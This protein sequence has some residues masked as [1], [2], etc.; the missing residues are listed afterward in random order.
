MPP[1]CRH[2]PVTPLFL[3][4]TTL[5]TS[6][7]HAMFAFDYAREL[8]KT[9]ETVIA[10]EASAK[11][12]PTGGRPPRAKCR[13]R[14]QAAARKDRCR[15]DADAICRTAI[16]SRAPARGSGANS[17]RRAPSKRLQRNYYAEAMPPAQPLPPYCRMHQRAPSAPFAKRMIRTARDS[18]LFCWRYT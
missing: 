13:L 9:P 5:S 18:R 8:R 14:L 10:H 2:V 17:K 15:H 6:R 12:V 4:S 3:I 1:A 11:R 7:R 16:P